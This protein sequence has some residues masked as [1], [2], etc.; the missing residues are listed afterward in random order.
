MNIHEY[1][2]LCLYRAVQNYFRRSFYMMIETCVTPGLI[3]ARTLE[4]FNW[5]IA[6]IVAYII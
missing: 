2:D 1:R 6:K 5:I 4:R 3:D